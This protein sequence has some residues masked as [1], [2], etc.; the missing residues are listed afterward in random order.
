VTLEIVTTKSSPGWLPAPWAHVKCVSEIHLDVEHIVVPSFK[1]GVLR[2]S[3]KF[4]PPMVT[5]LLPPP[6]VAALNA[7]RLDRTGAS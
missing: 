3:A 6:L 2:A 7:T 4:S 5:T 1:V